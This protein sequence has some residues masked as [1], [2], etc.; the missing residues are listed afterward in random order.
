MWAL[1]SSAVWWV[2]RRARRAG[3]TDPLDGRN[4]FASAASWYA[5]ETIL[6]ESA[7]GS[8]ESGTRLGV[9]LNYVHLRVR[10]R[11]AVQS[12]EDGQTWF[13]ASSTS[14]MARL[15]SPKVRSTSDLW[16]LSILMALPWGSRHFAGPVS[17]FATIL[18]VNLKESAMRI[19]SLSSPSRGNL[20]IRRSECVFAL[21]CGPL[22]SG[23]LSGKRRVSTATNLQHPGADEMETTRPFGFE[24]VKPQDICCGQVADFTKAYRLEKHTQRGVSSR[25]LDSLMV[26]AG[27]VPRVPAKNT[28]LPR[29]DSGACGRLNSG[30][31]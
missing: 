10:M 4:G 30:R 8:S 15:S 19:G 28:H 20:Q 22:M 24:A 25:P 18:F 29:Q 1:V 26:A 5:L 12:G 9:V 17:S 11:L 23:L 16:R 3:R 13:S 7:A 2:L 14:L 27:S 6:S 21:W 31:A